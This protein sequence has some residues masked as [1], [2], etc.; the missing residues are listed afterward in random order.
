MPDEPEAETEELSPGGER[1]PLD[2][3]LFES[4][5]FPKIQGLKKQVWEDNQTIETY[6]DTASSAKEEANPD[7]F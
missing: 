7:K 2:Y 5:I 6:S 1:L 4:S 3:V